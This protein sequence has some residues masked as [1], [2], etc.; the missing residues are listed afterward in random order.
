MENKQQ[1]S[2]GPMV[3]VAYYS[4]GGNTRAVAER[5]SK[6]LGS[7]LDEIKWETGA[8]NRAV[9]GVDPSGY[10]LVVVGTPVNGFSPSKPVADYLLRNRGKFRGLATYLTYSLWPAG[11]LKK[12][13]ELASMNPVA[14]AAFK[15][16]DIKLDQINDKLD[17]YL[18]LLQKAIV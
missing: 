2:K 1:E 17:A 3:L 7:D 10:D 9:F 13:G 11:S 5:I 4:Q 12:M 8:S 18:K 15:S 6:C 16:R 14:S